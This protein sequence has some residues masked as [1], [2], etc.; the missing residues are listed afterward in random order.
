MTTSSHFRR[1]KEKTTFSTHIFIL[2]PK[3]YS[4]FERKYSLDE[5]FNSS[6]KEYPC[7]IIFMDPAT[8]KWEIHEKMWLQSCFSCISHFS[9]SRTHQ[10]YATWVLRGWWIRFCIQRVILLEIWVKKLGDK[11]KIRVEKVVFPFFPL[12][13]DDVIKSYFIISTIIL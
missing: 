1:K 8:K 3:I 10:N 2:S 4:N 7:Y 5:K 13:F 12:K 11:L 9:C 6:S